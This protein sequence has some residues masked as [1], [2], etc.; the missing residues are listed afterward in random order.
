MK[1]VLWFLYVC[2]GM[3]NR[4]NIYYRYIKGKMII[5]LLMIVGREMVKGK[6]YIFIEDG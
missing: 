6:I 5:K 1:V 2:Y 3:V 4:C